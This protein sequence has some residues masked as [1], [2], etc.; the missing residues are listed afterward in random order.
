[1]RKERLHLGEQLRGK[2][3]VVT[4]DES[5]AV[6]FFDNVGNGKSLTATRYAKQNLRVS[7]GF[8][9]IDQR[10]NSLRLVSGRLIW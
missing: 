10:L 1:M 2:R 6:E 9:T 3:L 8:D 5:R 4:H 7:T